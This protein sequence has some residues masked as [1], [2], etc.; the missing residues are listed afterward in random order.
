MNTLQLT[1]IEDAECQPENYLVEISID[2]KRLA[3]ILRD[4]ELPQ[5]ERDGA[6]DIAGSYS[7]LDAETTL[8]PSLHF[9]GEPRSIFTRGERVTVLL[10]Q[11]GCQGCWDFVC[12][13]TINDKTVTWSDFA[14][15]HRQWSYDMLGEFVFDREQYE[16]LFSGPDAQIFD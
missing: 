2:G 12:R 6:P 8:Y 10:C 3:D 5:A 11:C 14:Q 7:S 16:A 9:L 15:T 4:V 1:V 13:I